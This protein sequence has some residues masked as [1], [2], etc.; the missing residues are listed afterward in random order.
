MYP[1]YN[2]NP[3]AQH[4]AVDTQ[5]THKRRQITSYKTKHFDGKT[6]IGINRIQQLLLC[7]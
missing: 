2:I 7:K 3:L 6:T 1:Q 5:Q 4:T